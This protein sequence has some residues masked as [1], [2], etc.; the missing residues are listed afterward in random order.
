MQ[1]RAG[2]TASDVGA[3]EIQYHRAVEALKARALAGKPTLILG[4]SFV[5]SP[6]LDGTLVRVSC[7]VP[8]ET[9]GPLLALS[10]RIDFLLGDAQPLYESARSQVV[11]LGRRV[12]GDAGPTRG[13]LGQ[14]VHGINRLAKGPAC[15]VFDAVDSADEATLEA[16]KQI[17]QRPGWVKVPLILGMRT[18]E[19]EGAAKELLEAVRKGFGEQAIL[20]LPAPPPPAS[21]SIG[22]LPPETRLVL[23]AA[24][25][26]GPA[27]ELT[28]LA[29]VLAKEPFELLTQLQHARDVGLA[30]E[31]RGDG[32]F[33]LDPGQAT[34]LAQSLMPSLR[35]V[36]H[37]RAGELL[38]APEEDVEPPHPIMEEAPASIRIGEPD[39]PEPAPA[40]PSPSPP[41]APAEEPAPRAEVPPSPLEPQIPRQP[42]VPGPFTPLF[43]ATSANREVP[44]PRPSQNHARAS[45]HL[46]ESGEF[47]LAAER[48]LSAAAKASA[49][50][51]HAQAEQFARRSLEAAIRIPESD[52][53]RRLR[54]RALITLGRI[55]LEGFVPGLGFD[56]R[57][58]LEPLEAARRA[59]GPEDPAELA[60]EI[61]QLTALAHCERGDKASLEQA[62]EGLAETSRALLARN[63]AFHAARLLNDQAAVYM[64]LGDPVRAVAL[65]EQSRSVFEGSPAAD[66]IATRELAETDHLIAKVP[67]HVKARPGKEADAV[68]RAVEHAIAAKR[69]F[70]R[71]GD[72]FSS[73]RTLETLGRL[74]LL[75]GAPERAVERLR[76]ALAAQE[77]QAD[78]V[79]LARTTAA[80]A[81]TLLAL[82]RAD[83]ALLLLADSVT[84]NHQKGSVLGVAFNRRSFEEA[85]RKIGPDHAAPS[86]AEVEARL[87]Q[88]EEELGT[89]VLPGEPDP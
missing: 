57:G 21:F 70:D 18:S 34:L 9:F 80:L 81:D 48:A 47:A 10:H 30:I 58:A 89:I 17:I 20:Q 66:A 42:R 22:I 14:I 15:I 4:T 71:L 83:E 59:L 87:A 85:K 77:R 75:R 72:A 50:G 46:F 26:L 86:R 67:L 41:A 19:P 43:A 52:R 56:L 27:F 53:S 29:A 38:S 37:R 6:S 1:P 84:L 32:T 3:L 76:A 28:L 65:L 68:A 8:R 79:G 39:L 78:L 73:A 63:H 54:V 64:K 7:D 40:S 82:E 61:A 60:V 12:L 33:A 44:P 16:L 74:E 31:D 62:L 2:G 11:E 51:A 49:L 23:R 25:V 13:T 5:P 24:A 36:L 55:R 45:E 35:A 88:A 69:S